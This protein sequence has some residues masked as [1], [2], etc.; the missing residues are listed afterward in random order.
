MRHL[1]RMVDTKIALTECIGVT[2]HDETEM[3]LPPLYFS[4]RL[5]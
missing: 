2:V 5:L 3:E 1:V 4:D